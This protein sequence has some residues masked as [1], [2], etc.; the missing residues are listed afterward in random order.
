MGRDEEGT[1]NSP[2]PPVGAAQLSAGPQPSKQA[3]KQ[4]LIWGGGGGGPGDVRDF[5]NLFLLNTACEFDLPRSRRMR[6]NIPQ[7]DC[8][9][10]NPP[11][12]GAPLPGPLFKIGN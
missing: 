4:A 6:T 10:K 9:P 2:P 7:G 12:E 3:S 11:K 1:T 8:P 5:K